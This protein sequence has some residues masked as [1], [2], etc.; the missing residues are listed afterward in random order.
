[1]KEAN[2]LITDASV[3]IDSHLIKSLI[4]Y[5]MPRKKTKC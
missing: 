1:M 4:N 2:I 5:S 3:F